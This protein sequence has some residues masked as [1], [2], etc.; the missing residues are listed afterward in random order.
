MT[1]Q[2]RRP[3]VKG[4]A[5]WFT[6]DVWIDAIAQSQGRSQLNVAAVH[7]SP[8]ARTA[9]HSH[10]GGQTLYVTEGRGLTQSRGEEV[11]EIREGD[12]HI[13]PDGREHWQG[14][15][16]VGGTGYQYGNSPFV[17]YTEVLLTSV[18]HE[19][20]LFDA[21]TTPG[22]V[23]I[24]QA[25]VNAKRSYIHGGMNGIDEKSLSELTL[26][27]LPMLGVSLPSGRI[28]RPAAPPPVSTTP[29]TSG[30]LFTA[31][32][33]PG[34]SLTGHDKVLSNGDGTTTATYFDA[35]YPGG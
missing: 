28:A 22:P 31:D 27:G 34:Y 19:L 32:L 35:T 12:V 25:I 21:G 24:G 26:Y 13:T 10:E 2:P 23:P 30:N 15:T 11:V 4:P 17:K 16:L 8:G 5:E 6:G 7:F 29:G 3:S 9:W 18:T 14:A 20:R 33:A 1:V